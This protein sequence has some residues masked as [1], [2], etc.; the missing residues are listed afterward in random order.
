MAETATVA[1]TTADLSEIA[2]VITR[3][4]TAIDRRDWRLLGSCF[5]KDCEGDYGAFGQWHSAAALVDFMRQ[6]HAG[7][8]PTLHRISNIVIESRDGAV[9]SRSY[10][11]AVLMP[12]PGRPE[13]HQ[14][15]GYY[16]DTWQRDAT[17]WRIQRRV[18]TMVRF[19]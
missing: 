4:A 10:V 14:G 18:F 2:A 12:G 3:Y 9:Y 8:G 17:G 16:D 11:D 19:L 5:E 6:A 1:L 13:A 15:I 7:V